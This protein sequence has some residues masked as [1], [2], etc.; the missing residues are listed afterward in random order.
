[1]AKPREVYQLRCKQEAGVTL[2]RRSDRRTVTDN[3]CIHAQAH[4]QL[5]DVVKF[6][7]RFQ[8]LRIHALGRFIGADVLA[9]KLLPDTNHPSPELLAGEGVGGDVGPLADAHLAHLGLVHVNAD[10]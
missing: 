3:E 4:R 7:Q 2:F 5:R 1:M 9:P 10:A 8:D 6:Q